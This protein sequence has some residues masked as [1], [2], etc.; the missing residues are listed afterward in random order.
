MSTVE[1]IDKLLKKLDAIQSAKVIKNGLDK[2]AL[3]VLTTARQEAPVDDGSLRAS[4]VHEVD[5]A[6]SQ[7]SVGTPLEYAPYVEFGTGLYAANG[8]G[9]KTPWSYQDEEGN[10]HTTAGQ[11]PQ[12]FLETALETNKKLIRKDFAEEI[13]KEVRK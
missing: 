1:G 5:V 10:W 3:R 4:I 7:A 6:A 8:D 12:P 2:A 11:Q 9:R 13:N